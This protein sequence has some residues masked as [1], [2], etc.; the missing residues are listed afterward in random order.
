MQPKPYEVQVGVSVVQD[1]QVRERGSDGALDWRY[2]DALEEQGLQI[3][4]VGELVGAGIEGG[5][6]AVAFIP[7]IIYVIITTFISA[8][9]VEGTHSVASGTQPLPAHFHMPQVAGS[10]RLRPCHLGKDDGS[11]VLWKMVPRGGLI[12]CL[13]VDGRWSQ[14]VTGVSSTQLAQVLE[15]ICEMGE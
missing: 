6:K 8:F 11:D 14:Q 12:S 1:L 5:W 2:R 13:Q 7:F 4:E 9:E 3:G 10:Q 15:N